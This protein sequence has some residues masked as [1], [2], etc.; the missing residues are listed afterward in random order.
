MI[1][2]I[3]TII[4]FIVLISLNINVGD[5][6]STNNTINYD[7]DNSEFPNPERGFYKHYETY[8]SSH[9]PLSVFSSQLN[10]HRNDNISLIM[11][12]YYLDSFVNADISNSYLLSI[13]SDLDLVRASG[14]KVILRFS[15]VSGV[16]PYTPP[17]GDANKTRILGH[18]NQLESIFHDYEDIIA[19]VKVSFIGLWGEWY[20]TDH[21]TPNDQNPYDNS[22][23][24][25]RR[26][27]TEAL[28]DALPQSRTVQVRT[29]WWKTGMYNTNDPITLSNAFNGTYY[30]RIGQHND[31]FLTDITDQGT[32]SYDVTIRNAQ[33][34]YVA[35]ETRY[36]PMG[37]ETCQLS[38]RSI[39]S[40]AIMEME[41]FHYSYL[42]RDY[43]I[44]ALNNINNTAPD[45][46]GLEIISK[47]LGYRLEL[48]N[49]I[50]PD[51]VTVGEDLNYTI[52]IN[53]S[54]FA[55][56]YNE[57]PVKLVLR[58]MNNNSEYSF[59]LPHDP[60][61]WL[62]GNHELTGN[63]TIPSNLPIG[64]YGIFLNMP[65]NSTML[66]NNPA[67]SVRFANQGT[68][69]TSTGYNNLFA[70]FDVESE[71]G[72]TFY[73]SRNGLPAGDGLSWAT[74]W[75]ELNKIDWDEIHPSDR[76]LIDGGTINM[77]YS[78][79]LI[80]GAS[81][82][83]D[84]PIRIELATEP[85]RDGKAIFFGGRTALLPYCDQVSYINEATLQNGIRVEGHSNIIIDGKKW[86]GIEL[87]GYSIGAWL[88]SNSN[89]VT[90]RNIE[91]YNNGTAAQNSTTGR[92]T[93]NQPGIRLAGAGHLFD[94]LIIRDNGT[95]AIQS[96]FW[97]PPI[98]VAIGDIT[99]TNSWLHN[100][101]MHP[102][103]PDEA[104]NYCRHTDGIQIYHAGL[105]G[106]DAIIGQ[107][108]G[109]H[110]ENSVF[111]PGLDQSVVLGQTPYTH[112]GTPTGRK[113]PGVK[114]DDVTFRNVLF[115]RA[116]AINIYGYR[117]IPSENWKF[118]NVTI[119]CGPYT[120]YTGVCIQLEGSGHHISDSIIMGSKNRFTTNT[121]YDPFTAG[122]NNNCQFDNFVSGG[123]NSTVVLGDDL[124][125]LFVD[126]DYLDHQYIGDY[127]QIAS[128]PCLGRGSTLTSVKQLAPVPVEPVHIPFITT[129]LRNVLYY[130]HQGLAESLELLALDNTNNSFG[131]L[132]LESNEEYIPSPLVKKYH[133]VEMCLLISYN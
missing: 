100:R 11:R 28:L 73:V 51:Q 57:R 21:F 6:D 92:W 44:D 80:V 45:S 12:H 109:I 61:H 35:S 115:H 30:S 54:G 96:D 25:D 65:D 41:E 112:D 82:T 125:P 121:S 114:V 8:A 16:P 14:L 110:I 106:Q 84:N 108:N 33:R 130:G 88:F 62:P 71:I 56:F 94:R 72:N 39:Y 77:T 102:D 36:V 66:E 4:V 15:Y 29:P 128:S 129:G 122:L 48:I 101:R 87:K 59:D 55:S 120:T 64:E 50:L 117:D 10:S 3:L 24:V 19:T 91:I 38:A 103:R 99:I 119:D 7:V 68:W 76:I 58:N 104:F 126:V 46:N 43:N 23:Y 34:N 60:R 32:Y 5:I 89:N 133:K 27:I 17:H 98:V 111:G 37:G 74:A 31:C 127:T 63:I 131:N 42:N 78:T 118:E 85:G 95:D 79:M 86:S 70:T 49:S 90:L 132:N 69:E 83:I 2:R 81:G 47:R 18:I 124:E 113:R 53:N 75:D 26:E 40:T 22:G 107:V 9:V 123:T 97:D 20:Y 116:A 105:A 52:N 67:Y 1:K 13:R 93:P